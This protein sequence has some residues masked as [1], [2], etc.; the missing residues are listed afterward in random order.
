[1]DNET[2][3]TLFQMI[4]DLRAQ[5]NKLSRQQRIPTTVPAPQ[6]PRITDNTPFPFDRGTMDDVPDGTTRKLSAAAQHILS[7]FPTATPDPSG[8]YIDVTN[9]QNL[10]VAG[11]NSIQTVESWS[12]NIELTAR[13]SIP[14]SNFWQWY[15]FD[16]SGNAYL[17]SI[18]GD[19][20]NPGIQVGRLTSTGTY[21]KI[22][23]NAAT[24]RYDGT[25]LAITIRYH[26]VGRIVVH[27][28]G[29]QVIAASDTTYTPNGPIGFALNSAGTGYLRKVEIRGHTTVPDNNQDTNQRALI[30][31]SQTGHVAK[32]LDNIADGTVYAR[33]RATQLYNG[34][35]AYRTAKAAILSLS[36]T[37]YWPLDNNTYTDSGSSPSTLAAVG[38]VQA[39]TASIAPGDSVVG[40][41]TTNSSAALYGTAATGVTTW[42]VMAWV[43][44]GA[45]GWGATTGIIGRASS[46]PFTTPTNF[47]PPIFVDTSGFAYAGMYNGSPVVI[48]SSFAPNWTIPHHLAA[49][50]GGGVLSLYVDGILV[51]Q[52][53]GLSAE[54][55]GAENTWILGTVYGTSYWGAPLTV[56][57]NTNPNGTNIQDAAVWEGTALTQAQ[58]QAIV[59]SG[60]G[61]F[62]SL[63]TVLDDTYLRMPGANMDSNRRALID[64]SQSGHLGKILDNIADGTTYARLKATALSSGDIVQGYVTAS[65]VSDST[66]PVSFGPPALNSWNPTTAI[67]LGYF[68][69]ALLGLL[70]SAHTY[71]ASST[72]I[73]SGSLVATASN[74]LALTFF[75]S[76]TGTPSLPSGLTSAFSIAQG[77]YNAGM[78]A[79]YEITTASGT[80]GPWTATV[81]SA[82][83][84]WTLSLL[85]NNNGSAISVGTATTATAGISTLTITKPTVSAGNLM[86]ACIDN[87][88]NTITAVPAGWFAIGSVSGLLSSASSIV[89]QLTAY[90]KMATASEPAS[91]TWTFVPGSGR[92]PIGGIVPIA[93]VNTNTIGQLCT[94]AGTTGGSANPPQGAAPSWSTTPGVTVTDGSVIWECI[95]SYSGYGTETQLNSVTLTVNSSTDTVQVVFKPTIAISSIEPG[96]QIEYKVY[97]GTTL[98]ETIDALIS[99]QQNFQSTG[100][101]ASQYVHYYTGLSG[102]VTLKVTI[103]L[104][105]GSGNN[106]FA[107]VVPASHLAASDLRR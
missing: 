35:L 82:G 72:S 81:S 40:T 34:H 23:G 9:V 7:V 53:T 67:P 89:I 99:N 2:T 26:S 77:T 93:N 50:L 1:M 44:P 92:N 94:V 5:V 32:V 25:T 96:D 29:K 39:S 95:G 63:S 107:A 12:G 10:S 30:D 62:R 76:T 71:V 88:G 75:D 20:T 19:G 103:K 21:T 15:L 22:V 70:Y 90:A 100:E 51:A 17:V 13:I 41:F 66:S 8:A 33:P 74:Q 69:N 98:L 18:G 80:Q 52:R 65:A 104:L 85:I 16:A 11:F 64:F 37:H 47:E 60:S 79:A 105:N 91:Y 54:N 31:F 84:G 24:P 97:N 4:E 48:K 83:T 38:T 46:P 86:I 6:P 56:G 49:T 106:A 101:G 28:N 42:T 61:S 58:I 27:V 78:R 59:T 43:M 73:T 57:W 68:I 36:P 55:P 3:L 45:A 14:S 87:A 102:S